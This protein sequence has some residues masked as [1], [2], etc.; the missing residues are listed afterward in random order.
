MPPPLE[1]AILAEVE[2]LALAA[3]VA[4]GC[5]GYSRV[6]LLVTSSEEC[7]VL[8]VNTLPGMTALSLFPEIAGGVGIPFGELLERIL[9]ASSLKIGI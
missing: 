8:E 6:D 1:P 4:L 7:Y 9:L 2:R 3:H 5:S